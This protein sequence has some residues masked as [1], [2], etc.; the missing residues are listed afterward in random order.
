MSRTT[1][2]YPVCLTSKE[3]TQLLAFISK[4][5]APARSILRAHIL[6]A[7]DLNQPG[8]KRR[9]VDIA[10]SFHIHPTT[11]F[12]IRKAFTS[13]GMDLLHRKKRQTPPIPA[14]ITGEVEAKIIALSCSA[15]PEGSAGWSLQLL[16]NQTVELQ[17]L[18]SISHEAVRRVLKKR[19]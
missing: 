17:I 1:T 16:A 12:A 14:K 15:P 4:G 13:R 8:G 3:R 18:D 10:A 5:K 11:V 9:D 7:T 19:N 6:L 2:V